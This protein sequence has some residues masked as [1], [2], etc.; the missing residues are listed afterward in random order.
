MMTVLK[1]KKKKMN[2]NMVLVKH[3]DF[4]NTLYYF[5]K[6]C[7]V[8]LQNLH[9]SAKLSIQFM[10]LSIAWKKS[11][12]VIAYSYVFCIEGNPYFRGIVQVIRD[13][14]CALFSDTNF[15]FT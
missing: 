4:Q 14:K 7:K 5:A 12:Y 1:K 15:L 2:T 10:R 8:V 11:K 3:S 13:I 6:N 9:Y